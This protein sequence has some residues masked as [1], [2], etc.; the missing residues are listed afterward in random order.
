MMM[1]R[2]QVTLMVPN[3]DVVPPDEWGDRIRG[4]I[5]TGLGLNPEVKV[6]GIKHLEDAVW[7]VGAYKLAGEEPATIEEVRSA[8]EKYGLD[9]AQVEEVDKG[10]GCFHIPLPT[11]I[12]DLF[13][14]GLSSSAT[15]D[16]EGI[17]FTVELP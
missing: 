17:Q 9:P 1:R 7:Y 3:G 12:E 16:I 13:E 4:F 6:D 5:Q 15:F 8:M 2:F 14:S 11:Q 10:Q